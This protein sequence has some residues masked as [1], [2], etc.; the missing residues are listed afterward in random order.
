MDS[1]LLTQAVSIWNSTTA[2]TPYGTLPKQ[3]APLWL[4]Q[5]TVY[6]EP[7]EYFTYSQNIPNEKRIHLSPKGF[8]EAQI[9][10]HFFM[11][12]GVHFGGVPLPIATVSGAGTH[13]CLHTLEL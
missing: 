2:T 6:F 3:S 13:F 5:M 4:F 10:L 1:D 7:L 8:S 11:S 12:G 9:K